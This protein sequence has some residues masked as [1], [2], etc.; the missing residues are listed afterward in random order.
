MKIVLSTAV[1]G[2]AAIA[3]ASAAIAK[4]S[5]TAAAKPVTV[6]VS[7]TEFKFTASKKVLPRNR[8]IVFRF[9]N[10][11][12]EVHDLAF[13]RPKKKTAFIT[14][15]KTTTMRITFKKKGRYQAICTVG[16]HFIRG[17][18]ITFTVK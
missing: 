11:G 17:M 15:G 10:T 13:S 14:P 16:E 18:K 6:N 2:L 5:G 1:L 4:P 7:G 9:K 8:V 3:F 12:D